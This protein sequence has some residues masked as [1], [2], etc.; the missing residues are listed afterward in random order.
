MTYPVFIVCRD[1]L[2]CLTDLLG[3][4][5]SVGHDREVYLIDN[6][7]TYPPLLEF[8]KH[9]KHTVLHAGGN[10]GERVGWSTGIIHRYAQGRRFVYTDPD[11]LPVE[12]CPPNAIER[13][14]RVL[15]VEGNAVKCGF[16]LK[17]D[18]LPEWCREGIQAWEARFWTEWVGRV[19]AYRALIDTT[20][21]LYSELATR[22]FKYKLSYR[23]PPPYVLRHVPWYVDPA[24]LS[25]EDEYYRT[26]A[27]T[28]VSNWARYVLDSVEGR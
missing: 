2:T 7:S 23:L 12:D 13:M 16:S 24:N 11:V 20:F 5:E 6:D 26:H 9:T 15:D 19:G 4:L 22:R 8:Y 25:D 17:V 14:A 10:F 21:A 1:R 3:W 18:D 28:G 27:D